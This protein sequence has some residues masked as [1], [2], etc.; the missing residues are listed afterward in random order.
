MANYDVT[1]KVIIHSAPNNNADSVVGSYAKEVNDYLQTVD[2]SKTIRSI[3]SVWLP[4][5]N[6]VMTT[7]IH[8]S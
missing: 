1:T 8:N 4:S 7:I 2:D 5:S 6:A 3:H